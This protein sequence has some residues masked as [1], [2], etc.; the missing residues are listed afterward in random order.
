MEEFIKRVFGGLSTSYIVRS[1]V[2]G[3]AIY[4]LSTYVLGFLALPILC[5]LLFPFSAFVFDFIFGSSPIVVKMDP[6]V[7]L[8]WKYLKLTLLFFLSPLIA[9]L[10]ILYLYV[11]SSK[12]GA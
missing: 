8:F 9:P 4:A 1:Y 10:G 12:T 2:I 6:A 7:F 5:F 11:T 3:A